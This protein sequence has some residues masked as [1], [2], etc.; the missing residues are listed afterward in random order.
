M[1]RVPEKDKNPRRPEHP[2]YLDTA[3]ARLTILKPTLFSS[4]SVSGYLTDDARWHMDACRDVNG[5][6][7]AA[8]RREK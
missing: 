4:L 2:R 3:Q 1:R 8:E 7:E 6:V 5:P